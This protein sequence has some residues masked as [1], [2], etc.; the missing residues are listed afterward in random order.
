MTCPRW[1]GLVPARRRVPATS[2][3]YCRVYLHVASRYV[4]Q[5]RWRIQML[6]QLSERR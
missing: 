6:A 4:Q 3:A 5:R 1:L 2:G